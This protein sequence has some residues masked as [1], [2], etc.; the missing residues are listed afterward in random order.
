MSLGHL[1]HFNF[2]PGLVP[3]QSYVS[4]ITYLLG[5]F[6]LYLLPGAVR[7]AGIVRASCPAPCIALRPPNGEITEAHILT[8]PSCYTYH[9]FRVLLATQLGSSRCSVAEMQSMC[10]WL[11]R[12]RG[13][14]QQTAAW[15]CHRDVRPSSAGNHRV[16]SLGKPTTLQT[17]ASERSDSS[18]GL[19]CKPLRINP[20]P[21]RPTPEF[22][23]R[24]Q[25]SRRT[26]NVYAHGSKRRPYFNG[27]ITRRAPLVKITSSGLT[28]DELPNFLGFPS[29]HD[30]T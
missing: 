25:S 8:D 10:R 6:C 15:G 22:L 1:V 21:W 28:N 16:D 5:Y 29:V 23:P 7:R 4:L 19:T 30:S 14:L 9:S 17:H 26:H 2:G 20:V 13:T 18:R 24:F 11:S 3:A 27:Y 12:A